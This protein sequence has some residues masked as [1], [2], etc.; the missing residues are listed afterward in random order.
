MR[1]N[2]LNR[3]MF[4][5][6]RSHR[7]LLGLSSGRVREVSHTFS[8]VSF[9]ETHFGRADKIALITCLKNLK[10]YEAGAFL[11]NPPSRG[12]PLLRVMDVHAQMH[13]FPR[14]GGPDKSLWLWMSEQMTAG[15]PLSKS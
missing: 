2:N 1:L 8:R 10:T 11:M 15:C 3:D 5:P 14:F 4:K 6:F 9:R 13:V 12:R 7:R